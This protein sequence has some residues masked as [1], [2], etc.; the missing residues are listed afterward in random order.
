MLQKV[1][2]VE[3]R[4]IV[5]IGLFL[6]SFAFAYRVMKPLEAA[7]IGPD[8]AAPV[9]H[10]Q[11]LLAGHRLEG[12]LS[13]TSKPLLTFVYGPLYTLSGQWPPVVLATIAAFALS[14]VLATEIVRRVGGAPAAAF[15]FVALT[16]SPVLLV[17]LSLAYAVSWAWLCCLGAAYAVARERPR[18]E[19]AGILLGLGALARP[20]VLGVIGAAGAVVAIT[21]IWF[22]VRKLGAFPKR[23]Y[24]VLLGLLA[25][26]IFAVHDWLLTG[27]AMFWLNTAQEN[28]AGPDN[29]RTPVESIRFVVSHLFAAGPLVPIAALGLAHLVFRR[30]W[31][32][33]GWAVAM[34]GGMTAFWMLVGARGTVLVIR[35]LALL[36]LTTVLLA[37]LGLAAISL[38]ALERWMDRAGSSRRDL[39]IARTLVGIVLGAAVAFYL[40]PVWSSASEARAE[41]RMQ[42]ALHMNAA[43]S[44]AAINAYLAGQPGVRQTIVTANGAGPIVLAPPRLRAQAVLDLR[45]PLSTV[46]KDFEGQLRF[47]A[48]KPPPGSIIYHDRLDDDTT[49]V[50]KT[51]EVDTPSVVGGVRLVPIFVDR[52]A[53]IWVVRVE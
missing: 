10:F 28:S 4:P 15:V 29:V 47:A 39:P 6:V 2:S 26:P 9:I 50:F 23:A 27:D 49:A 40:A 51:L 18:F 13:Q 52:S 38:P 19:I 43:R 33:L 1:R 37:G 41:I 48:G 34:L 46:V 36:D 17:D 35:Y 12:Y 3:P 8:A 25:I 42:L 11:H 31:T 16:L 53:G 14:V 24:L 45:L 44:L 7:S 20:E 32:L 22:R 5:L 21:H 30:A